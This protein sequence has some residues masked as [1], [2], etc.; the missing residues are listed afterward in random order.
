MVNCAAKSFVRR[1]PLYIAFH[2]MPNYQGWRRHRSGIL[3][4]MKYSPG[5]GKCATQS[6][7]QSTA[8]EGSEG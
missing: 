6:L 7:L 3:S 8:A 1:R 2:R 4:K 5:R